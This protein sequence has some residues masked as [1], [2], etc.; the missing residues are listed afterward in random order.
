M[1]TRFAKLEC[2]ILGVS[3]TAIG[4]VTLAF[5]DETNRYHNL[6]HFVTGLIALFFGFF[7]SP[8]TASSFCRVFGG[9][10]LAFGILG[11]LV[12]DP[13]MDRLW[14]VGPLHLALGDHI[15]HIVLGAVIMAGGIFTKVATNQSA[16]RTLG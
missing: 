6:L 12:G 1:T 11:I 14:H 2:R 7:G 15:F 16:S 9:A 3:F 5:G 8:L 4:L 13:T 10:Y